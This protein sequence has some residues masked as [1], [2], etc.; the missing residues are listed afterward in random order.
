MRQRRSANHEVHDATRG[1]DDI[2]RRA[3]CRRLGGSVALLAGCSLSSGTGPSQSG[4]DVGRLKSRPSTPTASLPPGIHALGLHTDRDGWVLVPAGYDASRRWPLALFFHGAITPPR[5]YMD[6]FKPIADE[7]GLV[8]VAPSS[9]GRTWDRVMGAFA[10]DPPFIDRALAHV[11]ARVNTDPAR[12]SVS[13]FSDGGSYALS[14]GI[15]NGDVFRHI[16]A[17][18]PGFMAPATPRGKPRIFV[19][20]GQSDS[21]LPIETTSRPIVSELRRAGYEVDFREFDGPHAVSLSLA[22]EAMTRMVAP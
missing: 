3:F 13:G 20:H 21:V 6:G 8:L 7:L 18:S 15:T 1:H 19:S 4:G 14:L 12:I 9:R 11:F 17:Y 16:A 5:Y 10:D 22:R 2:T